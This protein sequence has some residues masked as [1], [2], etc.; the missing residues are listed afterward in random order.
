M[1]WPGGYPDTQ[2]AW[3]GRAIEAEFRP[4]PA[5]AE[6]SRNRYHPVIPL[7][8]VFSR[9]LQHE[10]FPRRNKHWPGG[11]RQPWEEE[12]KVQIVQPEERW[13]WPLCR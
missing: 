9:L 2:G 1:V 12:L 3:L 6:L 4:S 13:G 5:N 8:G 7:K 11:G 10:Q